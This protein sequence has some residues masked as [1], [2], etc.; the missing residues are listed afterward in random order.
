[1]IFMIKFFCNFWFLCFC[2]CKPPQTV[3]Q[4]KLDRHTLR[5]RDDGKN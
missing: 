4:S 1:M 5:A 2:H 3:K